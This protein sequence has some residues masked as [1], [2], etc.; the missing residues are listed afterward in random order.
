[1]KRHNEYITIIKRKNNEENKDNSDLELRVCDDKKEF[2]QLKKSTDK[3]QRLFYEKVET[4]KKGQDIISG[5]FKYLEENDAE[6]Y[7]NHPLLIADDKKN[8]I[9]Y[10]PESREAYDEIGRKLVNYLERLK[11]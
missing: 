2:K 7:L 3:S 8:V 4:D 5:F 6:K 9:V 11:E 10:S 1:M